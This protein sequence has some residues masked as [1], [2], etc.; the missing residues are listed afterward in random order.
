MIKRIECPDWDRL[1]RHD[2]RRLNETITMVFARWFREN[3]EPINK[4]LSEGYTVY[5]N[6]HHIWYKGSPGRDAINKALVIN[7]EPIKKE[8]AEDVLRDI[9]AKDA[10]VS[11]MTR[12]GQDA[13]DRAKKVLHAN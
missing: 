8:T 6:G 5:Y 3:V 13:I 12:L 4:M 1:F 2:S 7:I 10:D 11:N 9:L